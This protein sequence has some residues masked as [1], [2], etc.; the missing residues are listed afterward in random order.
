MNVSYAELLE[1][2]LI[3]AM[4][5]NISISKL[6]SEVNQMINILGGELANMS[7]AGET[8][9]TSSRL[10]KSNLTKIN[11]ISSQCNRDITALDEYSIIRNRGVPGVVNYKM[12]PNIQSSVN[13][14]GDVV[15][16]FVTSPTVISRVNNIKDA[17]EKTESDKDVGI[18]QLNSDPKYIEYRNSTLMSYNKN[19]NKLLSA[20]SK[21]EAI[22]NKYA[23]N[24]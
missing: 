16:K 21:L 9:N 17:R 2:Y 1:S 10:S 22:S 12:D 11:D 20:F 8:I 23:S 19:A 15:K 5:A 18:S 24:E 14:I 3:P 4:E 7:S 6:K 13:I